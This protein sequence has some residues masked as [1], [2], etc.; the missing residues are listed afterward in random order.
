MKLC[1]DRIIRA[2]KRA[3]GVYGGNRIKGPIQITPEIRENVSKI[4]NEK[5]P[6]VKCRERTLGV[7]DEVAL[8]GIFRIGPKD[9]AI[10]LAQPL[11]RLAAAQPLHR[12]SNLKCR[13]SAEWLSMD[14]S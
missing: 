4:R 7:D 12:S 14:A 9:E 3:L 1:W 5:D 10:E 11:E 6:C 2:L 8:T 13:Q